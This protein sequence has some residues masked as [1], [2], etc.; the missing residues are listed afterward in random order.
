MKTLNELQEHIIDYYGCSQY[1]FKDNYLDLADDLGLDSLD[2]I[3]LIQHCEKIYD[4][5]INDYDAE[6]LETL[7][8]LANFIDNRKCDCITSVERKHC[9]RKDCRV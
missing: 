7:H 5:G 9:K 1:D 2:R 6:K 3:E 8:Q 4:I